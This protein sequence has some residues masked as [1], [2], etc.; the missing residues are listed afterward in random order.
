MLEVSPPRSSPHSD[1]EERGKVSTSERRAGPRLVVAP[2]LHGKR[3]SRRFGYLEAGVFALYCAVLTVVLPNHEKWAD[4]T[5]AWLLASENSTWQI[6][7]YRLHYEGTPPIWHLLLHLLSR[8]HGNIS[9]MGWMGA[10]FA[11]AGIFVFLKASPFPRVIRVLAPFTFFLQYQYAVVARSYTLFALLLFSLC[12]LF[13][14]RRTL[15]FA[16]VAGLFANLS[17]HA[18][19]A[20]T[21]FC[22]L[23][24]AEI[25]PEIKGRLIMRK[26]VA[27]S[28]AVFVILAGFGA[29]SA[30]PAPDVNFAVSQTVSDGLLNRLLERFVG[31]THNYFPVPAAPPPAVAPTPE[32]AKP[33]LL[34]SPAAWA[35]WQID[36][37][38]HDALGYPLQQSW[39]RAW[40]EFLVSIAS[41]ATWPVA[42]SNLIACIFLA[43]L[44]AWLRA[45]RRL[46]FL[47]PWFALIIFGQ[48]VWVADHHVGML[49]LLIIAAAWLAADQRGEDVRPVSLLDVAF[50]ATFAVVLALQVGW[51]AVSVSNDIREPY[52]PG[53]E[54]AQWM[55]AHPVAR[56]AAFHYWSVATQ[57]Y[58]VGNPYFNI[59]QRYW[60][61]SWKANP[62]P[63]YQEVIAQRP[64]RIVDSVE[65]P[66]QG[67]MRDQWIPLNHLPTA[68]E[69]RTLPWDYA[70]Q[71]FHEQGYVETHR[72]CGTRF[73]RMGADFMDCNLILEPARPTD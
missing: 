18:F 5:Q 22:I 42:N 44:F 56:T 65:F 6:L 43:V 68:E 50:E 38:E 47:L 29:Y 14:T 10:A 2:K 39:P 27:I 71:Y 61:W 32:P 13:R 21:L 12:A 69:R 17:T 59:P 57:P 49:F 72:F 48:L 16:I 3:R 35:G 40:A 19:I 1:D 67:Q 20:S 66:L 8:L 51:T 60:I 46:R 41:Q 33:G 62:D 63:Y 64:D 52:D 15:P 54:T 31:E 25:Y 4:E 45:R 9:A 7:R 53:K 34:R 11:A 26:Q 73:I 70:L 23:Y 37:R 28:G 30:I 55:L 58:F 24:L 36:H